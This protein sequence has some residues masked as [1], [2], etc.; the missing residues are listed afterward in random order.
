MNFLLKDVCWHNQ[1]ANVVGD[2]RISKGMILET[3]LNLKPKKNDYVESFKGHFL[4][5]GLINAHDHLE[6]NLYPRLG[7]PPYNNYVEWAKDIYHP[8]KSPIAEIE[9]LDIDTR[10]LWGGVKNLIGCVTTV[11]HHNPWHRLLAT[12][13]FPVK[14]MKVAW[15]HSLAFEKQI[16]KKYPWKKRS[17]FVVHVAEGTDEFALSEIRALQKLNLL[18]ENTVLVHAVA[19]N[20]ESIETLKRFQC[21]VVWCPASNLFMF[22]RTA[23]VS[24]LKNQ[25][26]IALGSDSTLTGSTTLLE[27]MN[28]AFKVNSVSAREIFEMV[29]RKP[30][31]IF[32]L[33][34]P[35]IAAGSPADLFLTRVKNEDYFGNLLELRP[36]DI[37]LVMT[38]GLPGLTD[39]ETAGYWKL[40]KNKVKVD[41]AW[42]Y[43]SIDMASIRRKIEKKVSRTILEGNPLWKLIE[44]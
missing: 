30:A 17:P 5:P 35:A 11:V 26:P 7:K 40:L 10:L 37:S 2:V 12:K 36:S 43:S 41:G 22:D 16:V 15:A 20:H 31:E 19:L 18:A 29:T 21:S 8:T 28:V 33:P 13:H 27:E 32:R 34:P 6:M 38:R 42:K 4:Y 25:I 3:G 23:P 24:E 9:K 1:K 14:V 44:I 39:V